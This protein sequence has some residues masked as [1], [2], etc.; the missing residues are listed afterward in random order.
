MVSKSPNSARNEIFF[1]PGR[2]RR[3]GCPVAAFFYMKDTKLWVSIDPT[4]KIYLIISKTK[5]VAHKIK[6]LVCSV[7]RFHNLP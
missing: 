6:L 7:T 4:I 5:R 3:S 2:K 1:G